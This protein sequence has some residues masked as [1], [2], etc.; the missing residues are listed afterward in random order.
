LP[1]DVG[2]VVVAAGRGRRAGAGPLK[3]FREIGGVPMVLRAIRP[4]VAHPE[5]A[6]V[7]VVLPAEAVATPPPWLAALRGEGVHLVPGGA[8]RSDSVAAGLAAL[9]PSC[10]VVLVHD[11]ARPFPSRDTIDLVLTE[12]R[13]GRA[14]LAAIPVSDTLKEAAPGGRLV[15]RTVSRENLWRAQTP[16]AFPRALLERAHA[17]AA[18]G[19]TDDAALVEAIGGSVVLVPDDAGNLKVTSE[20]DFV[21]AEALARR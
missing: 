2:V 20:E 17:A 8:E 3:Q 19:A 5:V 6:H 11:G 15:A 7:A 13:A 12:A 21:L 9:P 16:Q 18:P 4:F 1:R 14:A 10:A